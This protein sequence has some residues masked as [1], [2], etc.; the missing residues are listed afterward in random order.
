MRY[1]RSIY[2][3]RCLEERITEIKYVAQ[4]YFIITI[5]RRTTN[6]HAWKPFFTFRIIPN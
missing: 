1:T 3:N 4:K 6:K 2:I 5:L